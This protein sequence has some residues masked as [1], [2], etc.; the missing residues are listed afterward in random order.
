MRYVILCACALLVLASGNARAEWQG[1]IETI[2]GVTHVHNPDTPADGVHQLELEPVWSLGGESDEDEEIFGLVESVLQDEEGR[3]Y[4]LDQQLMEIRVFDAQGRYL[5][6]IGR[7]GEGPGEFRNPRGMF[8]LPDGRIGVIQMMP[9]RIAVL[10]REGEGYEDFPLP[11]GGGFSMVEAVRPCGDQLAV[12]LMQGSFADGKIENR[13]QLLLLDAQGNEQKLVGEF[14]KEFEATGGGMRIEM[15]GDNFA[16]EWTTGPD[17]RIYV[18]ST[19]NGYEIEVYSPQGERERVIHRDYE[20]RHRTEEEMERLRKQFTDRG[21]PGMAVPEIPETDPD[22]TGLDVRPNGE[23]WVRTSRTEE[24]EEGLGRIDVF[25]AEGRFLRQVEPQ[26]PY[27]NTEDGFVIQGERFY[28]IK[29][30][31]G[32]LKAWAAGFGGGMMVVVGNPD[33]DEEEEGEAEP[34]E[35]QAYRLPLALAATP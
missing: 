25:D 14:V 2:E 26:V 6:S 23:I 11:G 28:R 13:L 22:I 16:R 34:L 9:G 30:L 32:A 8:F 3:V 4:L 10:D 12:K 19:Y 5:R 17:G 29:E 27:D 20:P 7:E 15:G 35:I 33:D 18:V 24:G 31:N 21:A 1:S